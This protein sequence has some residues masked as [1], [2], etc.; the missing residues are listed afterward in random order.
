MS[1]EASGPVRNGIDVGQLM[2]AIEAVKSDPANGRLTFVVNSRWKGGLRSEHQ[3]GTYCVGSQS[4]MHGK[5][6]TLLVDEPPEVL[7]TDAGMSPAEVIMSALGSCLS[8]GYSANAAAMGID[9]DEISLE[10]TGEGSLE[11]FMNLRDQKPGLTGISIKANVKSR[12]AT[13]KQ[14]QDLHDYVNAHSPIWDTIA[15]PV[16]ITSEL[17]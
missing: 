16:K 10:I 7:G 4:A 15:N 17:A 9:I 13:P 2:T 6:H 12:N 8:V 11:G 5:A 1:T 14:L 3:P